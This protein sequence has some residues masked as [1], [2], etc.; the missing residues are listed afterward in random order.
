MFWLVSTVGTRAEDGFSFPLL[1]HWVQYYLDLGF[2]PEHWKISLFARDLDDNMEWVAE[3]FTAQGIAPVRCYPN[4]LQFNVF[5]STDER[6]RIRSE[7]PP[8]DWVILVDPDEFYGYRK[9]IQQTLDD[10]D[11]A[12]FDALRGYFVD[13]VA[14]DFSLPEVTD[15]PLFDQFPVETSITQ[16]IT[17]GN[18][19]KICAVKN[20]YGVILGHHHVHGTRPN[21]APEWIKVHHFKWTKGLLKR[22]RRH[23]VLV[24]PRYWWRHENENLLKYL[25]DD[26]LTFTPE[27]VKFEPIKDGTP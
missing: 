27:Q 26:R 16:K 23:Q 8:E 13:R 19:L 17:T 14:A 20:R 7:L 3:W 22:V 18:C 9:P 12:G 4:S 6:N 15:A 5:I 10:M 11:A 25:T 1:K 21:Y 2:S 24:E